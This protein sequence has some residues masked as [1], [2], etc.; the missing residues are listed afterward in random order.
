LVNDK[1]PLNKNK[2]D[3]F[4]PRGLL[5]ITKGEIKTKKSFLAK[6]SFF[7]YNFPI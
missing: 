3:P 5:N 4:K 2:N 1:F 6:N 7:S